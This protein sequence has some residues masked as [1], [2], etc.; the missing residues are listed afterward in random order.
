MCPFFGLS[1]RVTVNKINAE[2]SNCH[3]VSENE[4]LFVFQIPVDKINLG[5]LLE[6]D[7]NI[8][9]KSQTI[10][11]ITKN[12]KTSVKI[13]ENDVHDLRLPGGHGTSRFPSKER[14]SGA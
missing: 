11:N 14:L 6:L 4:I 13:Q 10:L 2:R 7:P 8:L 5:D 12:T 3:A 9:E 1:M